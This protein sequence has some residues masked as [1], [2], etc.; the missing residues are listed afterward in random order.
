[1]P[2]IAMVVPSL[3]KGGGVT[4]VARFIKDVCIK[5]RRYDIKLI[6]LCM[7]SNDPCSL[8]LTKP[9]SWFTG[10]QTIS[11]GVWE[12]LSFT[13]VG[14]KFG[15]IEFQRYQTRD[16]LTKLISDCDIIQVVCGSP[17][18]ANTVVG[19]G[20]PV[21]LQVATRAKIERRV[22]DG[23]PS[24]LA[25]YWRKGM[26]LITDYFDN[27]SLK[28]VDAIQVENPWMFEYAKRINNYRGVDL[29]YAPPGI[30]TNFFH[31][32]EGRNAEGCGYILCVGRLSDPRKNVNLL[33]DAYKKI[34]KQLQE[35]YPLVLAGF[36]SPP[37]NFWK[38]VERLGLSGKVRYIEKPT[39]EEL[40]K[41]YQMASV[42]VLPSDEEGLGLVVLEAMSCGVPVVATKC[43]GPDGII[44]EGIDGFL[45]EL[46][47]SDAMANKVAILLKDRLLNFKI[48]NAARITAVSRY[49]EEVAGKIF[50]DIWDGIRN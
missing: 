39:H 48:G 4:T 50:L 49:D 22:R 42:F 38:N 40:L 10:V 46:N 7:S 16:A 9:Q 45:V 23:H 33:L 35:N 29:R 8:Q 43:G 13:H 25:D 36:S 14:A 18:W 28:K 37:S 11:T 31:S 34:N 12:G 44:T 5:S 30:N 26:T 6:S 41:L 15:E 20:K 19:L 2:K 3:G 21:S 47:D 24:S 17:A 27:R 1:M 32:V